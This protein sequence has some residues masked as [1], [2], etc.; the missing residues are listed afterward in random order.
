MEENNEI[1]QSSV[2]SRLKKFLEYKNI[3]Q[4]EFEKITSLSNGYINNKI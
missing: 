2:K 1:E 4:S 3:G